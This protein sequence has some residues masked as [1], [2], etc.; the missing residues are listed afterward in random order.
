[1]IKTKNYQVLATSNDFLR[2][3]DMI[4]RYF[5]GSDI[6]LNYINDNKWSVYNR[7]GLLRGFNVQRVKDR[8]QF[9]KL[10]VISK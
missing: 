6:S 1:M 5:Y 7:K 10:L 4:S 9:I 8:Y 2:I 3:Q